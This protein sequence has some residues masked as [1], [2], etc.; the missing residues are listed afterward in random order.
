MTR[1]NAD[2]TQRTGRSRPMRKTA[3]RQG[4]SMEGFYHYYRPS[5]LRAYS[6]LS[7]GFFAL[8]RKSVRS[9]LRISRHYL[10]DERP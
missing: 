7:K 6:F 9:I 8:T 4:Y 10:G 2:V 3:I 5:A 1:G